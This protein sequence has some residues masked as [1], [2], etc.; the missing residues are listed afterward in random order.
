[1]TK[2][3]ALYLMLA[4][5]A[6]SVYDLVSDGGLYGPGKP[7]EKMR[8]KVYTTADGKNWYVSISDAAAVIGAGIYFSK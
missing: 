2:K 5:A 3:T 6:A 8:W 7:L 1:M 4:G